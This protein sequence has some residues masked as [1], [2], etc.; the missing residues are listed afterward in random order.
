MAKIDLLN[1]EEDNFMGGM[2]GKK[3]LVYG[4]NDV[5]KTKQL[6]KLEKPLL[7]M[8]ES[9]GSAVKCKKL[10]ITT[11]GRFKEVTDSLTKESTLEQMKE[12]FQSII[13][14]TTE[15]L[16]NLSERAICTEFGVRDLSEIQGKSNGYK[17]ARSDFEIQINKLTGLGYTV[18]F[19]AHEEKIEM[20]DEVT[21]ETYE[22]YQPKGT[23]NEKGSMRMIRDLCDF[24]IYLK[25][26]GID[27]TTFETIP[28]TAICKRTKNVFARSR[29]A[30]QTFI[31]P[32]T[33]QGLVDAI[34]L[35]VEKSAE[36]EGATIEA[37]KIENHDYTVEDYKSIIK[38]YMERLYPICS[39][40]V[41]GIISAQLGE[42]KRVS[43]ATE[44]D[45]VG[46]E[47]IYNNL[48]TLAMMKG[49]S[50]K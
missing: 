26:N 19:I 6:T 16:V 48:E 15:N 27:P 30:I 7:L 18:V 25:P 39:S 21:G 36:D 2:E 38:P 42:G 32:F 3:I 23:S 10:P 20:I 9:G 14:D 46:L 22:F 44:D 28:S 45:L 17:L 37:F 29:F 41:L 47:I 49:V 43:E 24:C 12:K 8:T 34:N 1:L 5:G 11:W 31:N 13:I 40:E 35:A 33:A 4:V 50:V